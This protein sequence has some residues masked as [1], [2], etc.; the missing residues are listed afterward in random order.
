MQQSKY[1]SAEAIEPSGIMSADTLLS[2]N[3]KPIDKKWVKQCSAKLSSRYVQITQVPNWR[4]SYAWSRFE[5]AIIRYAVGTIGKWR[6]PRFCTQIQILVEV[7]VQVQVQVCRWYNPSGGGHG[8]A[9]TNNGFRI[10]TSSHTGCKDVT[11]F[12]LVRISTSSLS[13]SSCNEVHGV[14]L[15]FL[16]LQEEEAEEHFDQVE[17][18]PDIAGLRSLAHCAWWPGATLWWK[19]CMGVTTST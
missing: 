12:A 7:Q 4:C 11:D 15:S 8:S 19:K 18:C 10:C 16:Q 9:L 2:L 14:C 3:V 13:H 1:H 17:T 5:L 6:W